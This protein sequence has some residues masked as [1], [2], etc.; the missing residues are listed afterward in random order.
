MLL[1]LNLLV[2]PLIVQYSTSS[3]LLSIYWTVTPSRYDI[4][5]STSVTKKPIFGMEN[6]YH[7]SFLLWLPGP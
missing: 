4:L 1:K 7:S 6:H 3:C 2:Q 5:N